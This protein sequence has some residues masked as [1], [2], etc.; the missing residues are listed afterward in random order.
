VEFVEWKLTHLGV[1]PDHFEKFGR[2][3]QSIGKIFSV[4]SQ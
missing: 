3:I 2:I 1:K 4:E